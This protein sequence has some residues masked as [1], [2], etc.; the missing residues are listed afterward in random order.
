[1]LQVFAR[2]GREGE[3]GTDGKATLELE[4]HDWDQIITGIPKSQLEILRTIIANG[5]TVAVAEAQKN[6]AVLKTMP[7]ISDL[8]ELKEINITGP[9]NPISNLCDYFGFKAPGS[10]LRVCVVFG[11]PRLL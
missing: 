8:K 4:G 9:R 11:E 6:L 1:V 5:S 3:P 2:D 7:G 10:K